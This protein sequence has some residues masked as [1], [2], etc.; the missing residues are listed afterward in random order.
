METDNRYTKNTVQR[1]IGQ[2]DTE[3]A[4][5][6]EKARGRENKLVGK[7]M[8]KNNWILHISVDFAGHFQIDRFTLTTINK[9]LFAQGL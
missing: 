2:M 3:G 7:S 9:N 1:E 6:R 8:F 4:R 5:E